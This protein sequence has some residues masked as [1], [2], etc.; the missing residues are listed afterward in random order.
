MSLAGYHHG[1]R[2]EEINTG[3]T[4]LRI[5][6]TAVIGLVATAPDADPEKFPLDTPVLFTNVAKALDAAGASGTL[7]VA[8][9]AIA[10]QARPVLVIVRVPVGEGATEAERQADQTSLVIGENVGGKR[11]GIQALLVA[12]QQLKVKPRILG[13]P[14]LDTKPVADALTAAAQK[15]RAMAYVS[16]DG[17]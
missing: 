4:T 16:A 7:P 12:Q 14:G 5:V 2:V 8:L 15:L 6:S 1:V 9:K 3:T 17:A 13:A 11:S 10:D